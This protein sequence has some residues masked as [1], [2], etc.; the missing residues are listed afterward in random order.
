MTLSLSRMLCGIAVLLF[1]VGALGHAIGLTAQP[2]LVLFW[3][4]AFFAAGHV[5]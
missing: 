2:T 1:V 4:L 5:F 3:G